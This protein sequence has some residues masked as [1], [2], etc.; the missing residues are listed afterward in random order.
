L[1]KT[2][3]IERVTHPPHIYLDKKGEYRYHCFGCGADMS[4]VD[5]I[6]TTKNVTVF[7]ALEIILKSR[8]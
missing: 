8:P 6:M 5:Y 2:Q 7:E 1:A 4:G 3:V